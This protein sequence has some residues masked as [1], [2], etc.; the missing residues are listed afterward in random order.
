MQA[1]LKP[2]ANAIESTHFTEAE[3]LRKL[4]AAADTGTLVGQCERV[5]GYTSINPLLLKNTVVEPRA[6][7][8]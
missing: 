8:A 7:F 3:R 5:C 6:Y 1:F 2:E 4:K